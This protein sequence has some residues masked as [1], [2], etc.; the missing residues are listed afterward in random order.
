MYNATEG[1]FFTGTLGDQISINYYPVPEDVQTWSYLALLDNNYKQTID[2]ALANL[3]AT[4]TAASTDSSL[5]GTES[6]TGLVSNDEDDV[7]RLGAL[8]DLYLARLMRTQAPPHLRTVQGVL[9]RRRDLSL[10]QFVQKIFAQN[11]ILV[12]I[13]KLIARGT[14]SPPFF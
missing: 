5:T 4:D 12:P 7:D 14:P 2:W 11:A 8:A 13:L 9:P 3:E 10:D 1:Y 6:F